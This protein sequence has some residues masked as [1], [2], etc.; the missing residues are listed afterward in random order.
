MTS[1][2]SLHP[3]LVTQAARSSYLRYLK[4]AYPIQDDN[5][6]QQFW[7]ALEQPD[8]LV[9]GPLLEATSEFAKGLSIKD[10]VAQGV[11]SN[12]FSALCGSGLPYDRALY[13][14]QEQSIYKLCEEKRN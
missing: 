6:R 7:Q 11:L 2:T 1:H 10:L 14:H 12:R 4:T 3:I 9:K 8:L 13:M 5:F